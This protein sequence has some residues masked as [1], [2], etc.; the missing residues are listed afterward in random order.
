VFV[1]EKALDSCGDMTGE[2]PGPVDALIK[3]LLLQNS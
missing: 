1:G 3:L 2:V